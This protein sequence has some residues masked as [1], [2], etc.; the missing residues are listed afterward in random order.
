[1]ADEA[2]RIMCPKLTCRRILAVPQ[3][4]RGKTVRCRYCSTNIRIPLEA[5]A[6][7]KKPQPETTG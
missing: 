2:L 7:P 4:A 5:A 6:A 1:M 3:K